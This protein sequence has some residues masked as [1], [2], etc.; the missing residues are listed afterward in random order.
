MKVGSKPVQSPVSF[1]CHDVPNL[2]AARL[3]KPLGNPPP[4]NVKFFTASE[5]LELVEARAW[6]AKVT[7]ALNQHWQK[8][9]AARKSGPLNSS[10]NRQVMASGGDRNGRHNSS[11]ADH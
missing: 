10:E 2:V 11:T 4:Y 1:R 6:L 3:L 9:N 5:L 8:R 7:N